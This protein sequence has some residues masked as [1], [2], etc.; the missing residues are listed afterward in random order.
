MPSSPP[1]AEDVAFVAASWALSV[2]YVD[3]LKRAPVSPLLLAA[4][5]ELPRPVIDTCR[6]VAAHLRERH[7]TFY[8]RTADETEALLADEVKAARRGPG[9]ID[10][11]RFEEDKVLGRRRGE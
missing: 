8:E 2:E 11:F 1:H 4:A 3:D 6:R 7:S 5:R 10:T 9:K